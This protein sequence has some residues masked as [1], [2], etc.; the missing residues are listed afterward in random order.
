MRH[1]GDVYTVV[2]LMAEVSI[3]MYSRSHK[4]LTSSTLRRIR[5]IV[6]DPIGPRRCQSSCAIERALS[7]RIL[8]HEQKTRQE[9]SYNIFYLLEFYQCLNINI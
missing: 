8:L 2:F 3:C 4:L 1:R 7:K 6:A 5:D 9:I